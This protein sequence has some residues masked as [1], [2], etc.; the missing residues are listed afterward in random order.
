VTSGVRWGL[1]L[2]LAGELAQPAAVAQVAALAEDAGWDGVFVWDHLWNRTGAP[3][4]DPWITLAAVALATE[5]VRIGTLVTPLPRRR[6]QVVAQQATTLDR[7][8]GGRLTLGLG[9][10]TDGYGEFS[11]FAEPLTDD[12]MRAAEL[13]RAIAALLPALS[14]A[15]PPGADPR[16]VTEPGVQRPRGP[17]WVAGRPGTPAGPRRAMRFGLEGVA[18]VGA[19]IWRADHVSEALDAA[20]VQPGALDVV[21]VGGAHPD[22]DELAAAGATWVV[23]EIPPGESAEVALTVARRGPP[24]RGG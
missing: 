5:R 24:I 18:L 15:S 4:A 23:P 20:R 13:E 14:G 7:L 17:V 3:F 21:L 12:G 10:G 9:L 2:A 19:A 11:A 1:S 22:A 8:S 6:V 16:W